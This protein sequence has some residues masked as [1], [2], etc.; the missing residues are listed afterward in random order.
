MS[1]VVL[2]CYFTS[3]STLEIMCMCVRLDDGCVAV[4][5]CVCVLECMV[6]ESVFV[7]YLH[8]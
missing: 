3:E 7:R 8:N 1:V 2:I 6:Y 4:C 5:V